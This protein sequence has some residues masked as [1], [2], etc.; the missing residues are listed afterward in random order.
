VKASNTNPDGP[1]SDWGLCTGFGANVE[2]SSDGN[3]LAVGAPGEDSGVA[4]DQAD[5]SAANAGA[6]YLY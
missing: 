5:V 1:C 2:L 6:V 4:N 3:T